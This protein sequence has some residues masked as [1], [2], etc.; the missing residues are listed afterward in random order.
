[1]YVERPV[2]QYRPALVV[3]GQDLL[4]AHG[5]VWLLMV[6]SAENARWEDDVPIDDLPAAGLRAPSVVR[7]A[8]IATV[9]AADLQR[10]GRLSAAALQQ[11]REILLRRFHTATLP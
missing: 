6:T 5:L 8:K 1:P 3:S 4:Q 11:V 7:A 2:R 10:L 9:Q